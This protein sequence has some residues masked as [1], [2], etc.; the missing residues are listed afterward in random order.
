V[1]TFETYLMKA[2]QASRQQVRIKNYLDVNNLQIVESV[3][4]KPAAHNAAVK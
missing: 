1:E 2:I 3:E 4:M